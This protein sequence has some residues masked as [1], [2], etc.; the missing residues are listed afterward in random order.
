MIVD[1]KPGAGTVIGT[2]H[3][4]KSAPDGYTLGVVIGA[5]TINPSLRSNLPYDTVKD[6]AGV[7]HVSSRITGCSR[8]RRS[9]PARFR[10]SSN[11]RRKSR[12]LDYATPGAGTGTHQAG[13]LL[14]SMA[15]INM[16]H[17][18]YKGSAA[19]QAGRHRWARSAAVRHPLFVD[20]VRARWSG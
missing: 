15:G 12:K 5:H 9:D 6:L 13:E 10:N 3:V 4:A 16:V 8:T 17:V 11:T 20:A 1:Y 14:N 19:A 18:P 7:S 2:D